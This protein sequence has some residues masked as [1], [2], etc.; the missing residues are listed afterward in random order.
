MARIVVL[1][2]AAFVAMICSASLYLVIEGGLH[3]VSALLL[4]WGWVQGPI[5]SDGLSLCALFLSLAVISYFGLRTGES[6]GDQD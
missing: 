4:E 6:H 5:R 1:L 2:A 3:V